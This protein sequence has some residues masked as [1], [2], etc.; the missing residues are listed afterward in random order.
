M[1][2][3]QAI[4]DLLEELVGE[5]VS[6]HDPAP[7][8]VIQHQKDGSAL[9]PGTVAIRDVNR[10]LEIEIDETDEWT[11]IGGLCIEL[12]GGRIPRTGESFTA[13]DGTRIEIVDATIRR[14]RMVRIHPLRPEGVEA[15][16]KE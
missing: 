11:T 12:A 13:G 16:S 6:E 10:E 14:V 4:E 5:I 1:T 3:R 8:N 9:V 2:E 15:S 7:T